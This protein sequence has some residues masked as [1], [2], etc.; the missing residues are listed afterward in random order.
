VPGTHQ[1]LQHLKQL[2]EVPECNLNL[3][4]T[5][6]SKGWKKA[7]EQTASSLSRAHFGHY[8]A[9][10]FSEIIN[11][12]HTALSAIPQKMAFPITGGKKE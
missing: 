4:E 2:A 6:H 1:L 3:T 9:G 7:K 12:V 5:L 10:T 11:L 8:K